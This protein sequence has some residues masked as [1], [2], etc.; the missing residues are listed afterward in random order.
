MELWESEIRLRNIG[1]ALSVSLQLG[2]FS[3]SL[4]DSSIDDTRV[5]KSGAEIKE[6]LRLELSK[7][8]E[9][10]TQ[11]VSEMKSL[12]EQIGEDPV[13]H[14]ENSMT[15][16]FQSRSIDIPRVYNYTQIYSNDLSKSID[17]RTGLVNNMRTYNQLAGRYLKNRMECLKFQ[18]VI[19]NL[20]DERRVKMSTELATQFGF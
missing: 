17:I 4:D 16:S 18:T 15:K 9:T 19:D 7:S 20:S 10:E 13:G 14:V 6:K 8:I 1:H 2:D 3:K 12:I 5:E 11:L